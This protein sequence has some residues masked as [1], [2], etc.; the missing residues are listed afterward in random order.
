MLAN[1]ASL[2]CVD[3]YTAEE[4]TALAREFESQPAEA[5]LAWA[6]EQFAPRLAM[7]SSFG[8][9]G[10]VLID[11][12][13]RI[14]SG[15]PVIYLDT[16]YH[17]TA[18][19]AVKDAVK[20]RYDL[21]LIEQRTALT[22]EQQAALYGPDLFSTQADLCCQIRKV[23]PLREA[24]HP[25]DGWLVALR[26]D[27]SA[28]RANIQKIEWNAKHQLV[29]INPLADWT[30]N[31]VWSYILK[32]QLPYNLLHDEGYTSIGCEPCTQPTRAGQHEREGRW[33]GS[34]KK[35]CGLHR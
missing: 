1:A 18:T 5:L 28:T 29:K 33:A 12:L 8:P 35:E 30:R 7:T 32:H 25:Y 4:C 17:F 15:T 24:L 26:R 6:V 31:Q 11:L 16:G 20:K 23:E 34:G 10:I 3:V 21:H 19:T 9:E 22:L 13:S 27:Q 14:T 2:K